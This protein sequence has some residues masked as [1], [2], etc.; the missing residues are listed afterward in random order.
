M[1]TFLEQNPPLKKQII[2]DL[3]MGR[4][5]SPHEVAAAILFLASGASSYI[6]GHTLVVDGGASLQLANTPF[7][8]P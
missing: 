8:D 2:G 7:S 6:N 5:V 1:D 3:P 4:L